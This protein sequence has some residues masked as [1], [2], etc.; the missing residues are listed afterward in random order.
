MPKLLDALALRQTIVVDQ[1][2]ISAEFQKKVSAEFQKK[3]SA[4]I[5]QEVFLCL[6]G[7]PVLLQKHCLLSISLFFCRNSFIAP[8]PAVS[9]TLSLTLSLVVSS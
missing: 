6:F 8:S 7:L 5:R 3:V 4:E 9:L 2:G 1:K